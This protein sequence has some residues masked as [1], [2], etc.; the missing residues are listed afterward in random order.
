MAD[1]EQR[2]A[3]P[4]DAGND[5]N[6][7]QVAADTSSGAFY[8]VEFT[9]PGGAGWGLQMFEADGDRGWRY[10]PGIA[11]GATRPI[12]GPDGVVYF[13]W[14]L[15]N[16]TAV[17]PDNDHRWTRSAALDYESPAPS[18]ANPVLIAVGRRISEQASVVEAR[19]TSDG[20]LLWSQD[21]LD[22]SGDDVV[23]FT[24][25]EFSPGG[26]SAYFAA[27]EPVLTQSNVFRLFAVAAGG[28]SCVGDVDGDGV[29]GFNDLNL[30]LGEYGDVGVGLAGDVDG[31]GD[32]DF[33]DLN[34]LLGAYG[35]SC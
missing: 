31:D 19:R 26:A 27:I 6:Q 16:L 30:L 15:G 32:V 7:G 23:A 10:A 22:D 3:A 9:A 25:P 33:A 12:V 17:G 28:A 29:V 35:Q 4:V 11:S 2:F 1:G 13:G 34:M 14:D 8:M 20:E 5:F 18:P 24:R 21:L